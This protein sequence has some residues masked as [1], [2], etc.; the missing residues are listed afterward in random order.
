MVE[1]NRRRDS[2][3]YVAAEMLQRL[4]QRA[5]RLHSTQSTLEP[6]WEDAIMESDAPGATGA[7]FWECLEGVCGR[8]DAGALAFE[9]VF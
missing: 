1:A 3:R 6:P 7:K 5:H 2:P 9:L 4:L 8:W